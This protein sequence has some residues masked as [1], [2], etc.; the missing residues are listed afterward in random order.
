M[1]TLYHALHRVA[2]PLPDLFRPTLTDVQTAALHRGY[3]LD[4]WMEA[5]DGVV[6]TASQVWGEVIHTASADH[7]DIIGHFKDN[8]HDPPHFDWLVTGSKFNRHCF[9]AAW[10]DIV[11]FISRN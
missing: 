11:N 5:N 7:H 2:G 6:P 3:P 9:E 4:D 8:K 1:H 10:I